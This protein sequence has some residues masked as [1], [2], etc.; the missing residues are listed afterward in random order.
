MSARYTSMMINFKLGAAGRL[1][2]GCIL[3]GRLLGCASSD[4]RALRQTS[5]PGASPICP[6][7][8]TGLS[9]NSR[10]GDDV[11]P[12]LID[13]R[14]TLDPD[15]ERFSGAVHIAIEVKR[16]VCGIVL[17]GRDLALERTTLRDSAGTTFELTAHSSKDHDLIELRR[18]APISA[19]HY[20]I[21]VAYH[22][23]LSQ[24]KLGL[25]R[26]A[27]SG[28][29]YLFSQME[30]I[31]ARR[32]MPSFDEPRFKAPLE[33]SIVVPEKLTAVSNEAV[34]GE[35]TQGDGKKLL[36]FHPTQ[37]LP[38][39]LYALAVGPF[40]VVQETVAPTPERTEP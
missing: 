17:F 35:Q 22:A 5:S 9:P 15:A 19:G 36:V 20:T 18:G 6:P 27:V 2:V 13:L 28:E 30:P 23:S 25:Y 1:F 7:L 10:L 26:V 33:L 16:E 8:G 11:T 38:S 12:Q 14:L 31:G 29:S 4:V 39:Y 34:L 21:S 37:P 40:D 32:M 24:E 3:L